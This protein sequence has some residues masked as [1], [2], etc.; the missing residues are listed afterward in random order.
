M[1]S[2]GWGVIHSSW[3]SQ[4]EK[5]LLKNV[6]TSV[7]FHSAGFAAVSALAGTVPKSISENHPF[8]TES[9]WGENTATVELS[10]YEY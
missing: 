4:A 10:G 3:E 7:R 9:T 6:L 2:G 1:T 5:T 8:R